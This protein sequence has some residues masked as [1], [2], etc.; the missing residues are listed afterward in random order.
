MSASKSEASHHLVVS[1]WHAAD[2]DCETYP[3]AE[4]S[5]DMQEDGWQA[6]RRYTD[7]PDGRYFVVRGR[8][9]RK[10]NP[11][12]DDADREHLVRELMSAHRAECRWR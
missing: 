2:L 10:R 11:A 7:T 5:F 12:L 3:I 6:K 1:D 8:L 4:C 9:W